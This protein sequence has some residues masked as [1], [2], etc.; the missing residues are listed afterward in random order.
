MTGAVVGTS[1]LPL[2]LKGAPSCSEPD[3]VPFNYS[4]TPV[5]ATDRASSSHP[6]KRVRAWAL[7]GR[8]AVWLR[9]AGSGMRV[10]ARQR[11][12][13]ADRGRRKW[14]PHTERERCRGTVASARS[15]SRVLDDSRDAVAFVLLTGPRP[16]S[17]AIS[18]LSARSVILASSD[19]HSA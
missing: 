7:G 8:A 17:I 15:L 2:E 16:C 9:R 13:A 6:A 18:A 19:R 3:R 4:S 1:G 14:Q 11:E 10:S 5:N 12:K